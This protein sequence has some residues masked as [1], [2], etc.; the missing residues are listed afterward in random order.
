MPRPPSLGCRHP[1]ALSSALGIL[2]EHSDGNSDDN[3]RPVGLCGLSFLPCHV[4]PDED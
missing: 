1:K 3:S 4:C 2:E